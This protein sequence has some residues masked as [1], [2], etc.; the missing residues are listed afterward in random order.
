MKFKN[1]SIAL[2]TALSLG[3]LFTGTGCKKYADPPPFF[4]DNTDTIPPTGRK[5]LIIAIDG[6]V[7]QEYKTIAPPELMK[8]REHSKYNWASISDRESTTSAASWKT[9]ISG[10]GYSRHKIKDSTFIYTLPPGGADDHDE[11]ESFPSMFSYILSSPRAALRTSIISP[12]ERMLTS[13][14]SEVDD[15]VYAATDQAVKDS[16]LIR[17]KSKKSDLIIVNFN[18]VAV[19][20]KADAFSA[21]SDVYKA[22]VLKVDGYVGEIMAALKARP[23]YNK[24]E[25][26]MVIVTS[27]HGGNGD[28]FGG[29]TKPE[30]NTFE[31][32]YYENFVSQEVTL[33]SSANYVRLKRGAETAP[34]QYGNHVSARLVND[35]TGIYNPG[36]GDF[37]IQLKVRVMASSS[38]PWYFSRRGVKGGFGNTGWTFFAAG[39][40]SDFDATPTTSRYSIAASKGSLDDGNWHEI[41]GVIE[42]KGDGKRYI[43]GY[44]DGVAP[45]GVNPKELPAGNIGS[46]IPIT[47]GYLS[48]SSSTDGANFEFYPADIRMFNKALTPLE[49]QNALCLNDITQHPSYANLVGYWSCSEGSGNKFRNSAPGKEGLDFMLEGPFKWENFVSNLPCNANPIIIDKPSIQFQ[50]IEVLPQVFHWLRIP[51]KPEWGLD[52]SIWINK[53]EKEY[54]KL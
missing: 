33:Y 47:L 40:S 45:A 24:S 14:A 48:G 35:N 13:V 8:I 29:V 6:G 27:T 34:G 50:S 51:V 32:Y 28:S 2:A 46:T 1:I 11:I 10:V 4:E 3:L 31:F 15:N 12:W 26:W 36:T 49:M 16:A 54:I 23:D 22:A 30:Y 38:Y 37:T 25:E 18:S 53:F 20:G 5:V 39:G 52:G 42:K 19:A 43:T 9:L 17:V 41:S 7:G 21:S 44:M